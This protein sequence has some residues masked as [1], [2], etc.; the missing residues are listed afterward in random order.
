MA[1]QHK[2]V[3]VFYDLSVQN[4]TLSEAALTKICF[5]N[6]NGILQA[7]KEMKDHDNDS[8]NRTTRES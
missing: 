5:K 1:S 7:K 8:I 4:L 6:L 3:D 2:R